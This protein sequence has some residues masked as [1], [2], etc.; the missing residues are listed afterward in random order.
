MLLS[1][2]ISQLNKCLI[3]ELI[4]YLNEQKKRELFIGFVEND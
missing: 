2:N 4:E 1:S 3:E